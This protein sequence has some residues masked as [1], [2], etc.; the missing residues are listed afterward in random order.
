[1][2]HVTTHPV[3]PH[4]AG[5]STPTEDPH[6]LHPHHVTPPRV[7]LN[8]LATLL[9]LTVVTVAVS[10]VDMGSMNLFVAMG[11]AAV[12]AA[13]VLTFFMHLKYDTT[14]NNIIIVSSF[15]FLSLLFLFTLGDLSTRGTADPIMKKRSPIEGDSQYHDRFKLWYVPQK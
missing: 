3:D 2:A 13:L 8:V 11:I 4:H 10:R 15:L 5:E 6:D 9:A 14:M 7:F 12:K 1:M